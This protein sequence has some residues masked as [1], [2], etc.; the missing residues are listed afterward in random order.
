MSLK[1]SDFTVKIGYRGYAKKHT[2]YYNHM[3]NNYRHIFCLGKV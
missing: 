1:K 3:G 2:G